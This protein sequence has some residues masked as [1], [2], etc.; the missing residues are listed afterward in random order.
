MWKILSHGKAVWQLE[1]E[2]AA[3]RANL[4][5]GQI[6]KAVDAEEWV[7]PSENRSG[8]EASQM[9]ASLRAAAH[10]DIQQGQHPVYRIST[11]NLAGE[12]DHL[13]RKGG[14][15]AGGRTSS[16]LGELGDQPERQDSGDGAMGE[17]T[18]RPCVRLKGVRY[19]SISSWP[20]AYLARSMSLIESPPELLQM[21]KMLSDERAVWERE[22]EVAALRADLEAERSGRAAET[23]QWVSPSKKHWSAARILG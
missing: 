4:E 12:E 11:S 7:S 17:S 9:L 19:W 20:E 21:K 3:H 22:A 15:G 16:S 10:T 6:G 14:M 23:E 13:P 5:T 18:L 8:A 2:L 1:A